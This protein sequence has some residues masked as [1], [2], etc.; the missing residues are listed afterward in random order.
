MQLIDSGSAIDDAKLRRKTIQGLLASPWTL[1]PILGGITLLLGLWA[2]SI[3]SGLAIFAGL[4]AIL[5]GVGIF[6]SRLLLGSDKLAKKAIAEMQEEA[7][8][9]RE[10]SLDDLE[11]RL[12]AD[13]DPRTEACLRDLRALAKAFESG[14]AWSD[15]MTARSVFDILA[16]VEQLFK[17]CV[18]SLKKTLDLWHTARQM[19]TEEASR[20]ILEQRERMIDDVGQSIKQLGRILAGIQGLGASEGEETSELARIRE[21]LD[22]SLEVAKMVE[23]RMQSLDREI[24]LSQPRDERDESIE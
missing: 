18:L 5:G 16:G 22:R 13:G 11:R 10:R 14:R 17:R 6:F 23:K 9:K 4:A 24:G 1:W 15:S 8:Q 7:Q 20:P 2:L 12:V 3:R 21:E 19:A